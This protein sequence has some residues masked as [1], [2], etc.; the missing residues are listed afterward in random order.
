MEGAAKAVILIGFQAVMI[1]YLSDG[2][3]SF[4]LGYL[5]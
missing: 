5:H 2:E 4:D 1:E 3:L